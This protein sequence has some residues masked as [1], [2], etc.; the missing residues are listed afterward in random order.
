[1]TD[2]LFPDANPLA[3]RQ[4]KSD[5]L[6]L[7]RFLDAAANDQRLVDDADAAHPVLVRWADLESGGKLRKLNET[8]LQGDFLAQV[9]GDALGYRRAVDGADA[10]NLE[11]HRPVGGVV[12]DALLGH[13]GPARDPQPL[14]VVELKG[15]AVHLDRDRSAGRTAVDQC[16]DYLVN[17]PAACRWGIVSNFVSFRLYERDSTKRRYEHFT[18]QSLRDPKVFRRFYALFH[19]NGLIAGKLGAKARTP[20]LLARTND[21]QR[22]VGDELYELYSHQ[23]TRLIEELHLRRGHGLAPAIEWAQR[24]FDRV[25]FI[26]FCEDRGLLP[27]DTIKKAHGV[28]GFSAVTNPQWQS[29]R[30]LFR[31]VDAGG[32]HVGIPAYN[33]GLF[34]ANRPS[35]TWICPT[36]TPTSS[37]GW[38][39]TT[40]PTRSTSTSSGTCSSARSPRSKSS[41]KP[42]SSAATPTK[43]R[44]FAEMPQ[45]AKRKRL[46]IYY[47]PPELTSRIVRY[48]IDELIDARFADAGDD[49]HAQLAVLRGLK[50]VDPACGS[51]AFLF[52]A[53]DALELR[54]AQV[55]DRLPEAE[56]RELAP[57]LPRFILN[58]N[59]YGVDLSPEAVEITQLAL[60]IRSADA[61]QP[62]TRL[63]PTTSATATRS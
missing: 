10:W 49:P 15:A 32:E 54:Y 43:A 9:F 33:G 4:P 60:W 20:D 47:T 2:A 44:D 62:L 5:R 40:S 55:L 42:A 38:A 6:I 25:I 39:T 7:T 36:A 19:Y 61:R 34:A 35:T 16:W 57:Q 1:M 52:Q 53:Y 26:A 12:P 30:A 46:G 45:S 48:T 27:I 51:G 29:F 59:L 17:L 37:S 28:R 31:M 21:R 58:D 63:W 50:I 22:A 41:A 56:R 14:A 3:A 18:L 23:R 13:F 8:Q 11:Q 24:L